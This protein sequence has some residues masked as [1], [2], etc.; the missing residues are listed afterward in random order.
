MSDL[1]EYVCGL[2]NL[3]GA[4]S[5]IEAALAARRGQRIFLPESGLTSAASRARLPLRSTCI[6]R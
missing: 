1:A 4:E 3:C 5:E 6:S 2:P